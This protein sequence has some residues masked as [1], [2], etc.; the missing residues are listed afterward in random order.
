VSLRRLELLQWFG[1]LAGG[2]L[3][4]ASFLA[5]T[6]VAI[7]TCNPAGAQWGIPYDTVQ[8]ALLCVAVVTIGAAE[9]AAVIVFRAT[10]RVEEE[11]PPP[12]ARMRLF[13]IGAMIGNLLFLT[14][15]VLSVVATVVDRTCVQ[16]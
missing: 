3:W 2:M 9:A 12:Q 13:A 6:S 5:G 10:R 8:I 14:I 15:I 11:G 16:A 1:F 7:A 4:Y